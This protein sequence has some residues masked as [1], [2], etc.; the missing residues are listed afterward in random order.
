MT[1]GAI[2]Q[3]LL[4]SAKPQNITRIG[5]CA[6]LYFYL[7]IWARQIYLG[8]CMQGLNQLMSAATPLGSANND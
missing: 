5:Q 1:T 6:Q 8:Q 4:A 3:Q 2:A 7:R